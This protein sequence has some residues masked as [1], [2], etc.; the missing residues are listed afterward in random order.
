MSKYERKVHCIGLEGYT[1]CGRHIYYGW[2]ETLSPGVRTWRS[3][4]DADR[5]IEIVGTLVDDPRGEITCER[6]RKSAQ[7]LTRTLAA[8]CGL[9]VQP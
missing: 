6:C 8:K 3:Y 5:E 1:L 7:R 9:E 2:L 4:L